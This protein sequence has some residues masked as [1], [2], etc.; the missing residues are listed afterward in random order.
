MP[1]KNTYWKRTPHI[2][3]LSEPMSVT[4]VPAEVG[5]ETALRLTTARSSGA[6]DATCTSEAASTAHNTARGTPGEPCALTSTTQPA[7]SHRGNG[8]PSCGPKPMPTG[9]PG[10]WR[11]FGKVSSRSVAIEPHLWAKCVFGK[12]GKMREQIE[13]V[14]PGAL[15]AIF[16]HRI[17]RRFFKR[18]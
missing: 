3:R 16:L 4:A 9:A 15:T 7:P 5:N 8:E 11:H 13:N 12:L 17:S 10:A 14:A 18:R 1:R 6:A 2:N